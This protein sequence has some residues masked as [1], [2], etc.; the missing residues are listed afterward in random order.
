MNE[1]NH[2]AGYVGGALALLAGGVVAEAVRL[3]APWPGFLPAA[4][5]AVSVALIV[6]W[7]STAVLLPLRNRR[8][9]FASTARLLAVAAPFAMLAHAS[10]T[11]VGGSLLG[12]P[13][14]A[15]AVLLT[16][17]LRLLFAQER[18][19]SHRRAPGNVLAGE[20][21]PGP[22]STRGAI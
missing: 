16:V 7:A 8:G 11:R 22:P 2:H 6:L 4:S 21:P 15:G 13:Y 17:L 14:A 20:L 19:P 12:L 5:R 9:A 1:R 10:V 3:V 18:V